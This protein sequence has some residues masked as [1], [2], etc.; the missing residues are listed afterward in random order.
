MK[1]LLLLLAT[2]GLDHDDFRVRQASDRYLAAS[3]YVVVPL[4]RLAPRLTN[5]LEARKRLR[6]LESRYYAAWDA[7]LAREDWREYPSLMVL[8]PW[9]WPWYRGGRNVHDARGT[10]D[11]WYV[12]YSDPFL[13]LV[14][15]YKWRAE[16][17]HPPG[18]AAAAG[19]ASESGATLELLKDLRS[20]GAPAW[21]GKL[22]LGYLRWRATSLERR[23]GV[24]D[25]NWQ[26]R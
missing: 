2:W 22:I 1:V 7:K 16:A 9:C 18:A 21:A 20:R 23:Y 13:P 15:H 17:D 24:R 12:D 5:S 10:F 11:C 26:T 19:W 4:N 8:S 25:R 3:G 14:W 6:T